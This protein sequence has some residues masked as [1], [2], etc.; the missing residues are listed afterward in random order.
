MFDDNFAVW[1]LNGLTFWRVAPTSF[2]VVRCDEWQTACALRRANHQET[3]PPQTTFAI[4]SIK[5]KEFRKRLPVINGNVD[6]PLP[7]DLLRFHFYNIF[8]PHF[9]C[10]SLH[11]K[12]MKWI[13]KF[14]LQWFGSMRYRRSMKLMHFRFTSNWHLTE[15]FSLPAI[16]R[17]EKMELEFSYFIDRHEFHTLILLISLHLSTIISNT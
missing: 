16:K 11:S 13:I 5:I 2:G 6:R 1:I 4:A 12:H 9:S 8:F 14:T 7:H 10:V 17:D 3:M 15:G